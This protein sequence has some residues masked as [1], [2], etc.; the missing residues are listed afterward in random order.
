MGAEGY[1]IA[2]DAA[3]YP[4]PVT[5]TFSG[6]DYWSWVQTTSEVRA[7]AK[8]SLPSNRI[9]ACW[10]SSTVFNI[11]I[12]FSDTALHQVAIYAL[13]WDYRSRAETIR[14]L[15]PYGVVLNTQSLSGFQNGDYLVWQVSGHVQIQ[16]TSSAA[17]NAVVSGL[18]FR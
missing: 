15:N 9:A 12:A 17:P 1:S 16:V 14:I 18:F 13:D 11:D 2:G 10:F 4:A 8:P 3:S 6:N 5:V 7:L